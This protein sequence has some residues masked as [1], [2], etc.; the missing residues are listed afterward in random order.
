MKA[1]ILCAGRGT[2]LG[3]HTDE[4]PKPLLMI[5]DKSIVELQIESLERIGV[6]EIYINLNYLSEKIVDKLGDGSQ[7]GVRIKYKKEE[8]LS[9]TAGGVKLFED[10]LKDQ[11]YFY[12][13]YGDIVTDE[14]LSRIGEFHVKNS[15]QAS[16]YLHKRASSNSMISIDKS[17]LVNKIIERPTDKDRND[18]E[19]DSWVNSAIYCLNPSVLGIIPPDSPVDFPK[20]IFP[21]LV[22]EESLFGL[23]LLG[24]RFA[25]DSEERLFQAKEYFKTEESS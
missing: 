9:G 17:G 15:A 14:D 8:T 19:G 11:P 21:I 2:R 16:I 24:K 1:V 5:G 25:I 6:K 7:Y 10:E 13:L 20:D 12:V 3:S 22:R 23:E 4:L 18:W